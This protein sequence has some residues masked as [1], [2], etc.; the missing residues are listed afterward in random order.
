MLMV[1][2]G[3]GASY[4]CVP[5]ESLAMMSADHRPPLGSGLFANR[6]IFNALL[7]NLQEELGPVLPLLRRLPRVGINIEEELERLR[8][9]AATHPR[10]AIAINAIRYYLRDA[11]GLCGTY[12]HRE[13]QGGTFYAELLRR[14]DIWH[15]TN[16]EPIGFVTFNYDTLLDTAAQSVLGLDFRSDVSRYVADAQYKIFKLHGSVNWAVG[17]QHQLMSQEELD[18]YTEKRLMREIGLTPTDLYGYP[19]QFTTQRLLSLPAIAIPMQNKSDSDFACPKAHLKALAEC[20]PQVTRLLTIGWRGAERHF[21]DVLNGRLTNLQLGWA[22]AESTEAA[23]E[24]VQ[25]LATAGLSN[26]VAVGGG[27]GGFIEGT[28]LDTFLSTTV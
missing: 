21:L 11:L 10:T 23:T 28:G 15:L 20:L 14:L 13:S 17:I 8:A 2:F 4:D 9:Q 3:A 26:V 6:S 24:T 22:V 12:W 7:S 25:N 18:E 16:P 27:F 1:V 19:H 5:T